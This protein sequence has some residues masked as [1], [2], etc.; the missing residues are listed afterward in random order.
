MGLNLLNPGRPAI[1][2]HRAGISA[3]PQHYK[4]LL[5]NLL[6]LVYDVLKKLSYALKQ[7]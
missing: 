5:S 6:I 2:P 4:Q 7:L 3:K 1:S